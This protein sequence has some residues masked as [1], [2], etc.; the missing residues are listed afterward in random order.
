MASSL[1]LI[2]VS[3][4]DIA[5]SVI[6]YFARK[7]SRPVTDFDWT[8]EIKDRFGYDDNAWADLAPGISAEP[9]M[10]SISVKIARPEMAGNTSIDKL[11]NLIWGKVPKLVAPAGMTAFAPFTIP[12]AAATKESGNKKKVTTRKRKI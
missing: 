4:A 10:K 9:W 1:A 7:Q 8:T 5:N 6:G 12:G 3:K 11:T 2:S